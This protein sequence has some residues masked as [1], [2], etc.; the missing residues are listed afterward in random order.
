MNET[1]T[2]E[3]I[4]YSGLNEITAEMSA[5]LDA[6]RTA[7]GPSDHSRYNWA[8]EAHH[9]CLKNLV[10]L[11]VDWKKRQPIGLDGRWRV[12]EGIRIESE[13]KKWFIDIGYELTQSQR[14]FK[15]DDPGMEEFYDLWI[16]GKIDGMSPL[17]RKLPEPFSHLREAPAE[18]KTVNPNYWN[19]TKT[20]EDIKRHQ[21]FWIAKIPS[22]LNTYLAFTKSPGGFLIIV[23]FGKKPRI[24]PMLF[25]QELWDHDRA[26]ARK[27]NAHVEAGTYPEPMPFNATVC[28]MCDF[29]HICQPIR[30]T[31]M[32]GIDP[33]DIFKLEQYLEFKDQKKKFDELHAELIGTKA[34]P[35]KYHGQDGI[36]EDIEIST[37]SY[38]KKKYEIPGEVK[39]KYQVDDDEIITTKIER[40]SP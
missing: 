25:D 38:M 27:V 14:K 8:S 9:P 15:T 26:V 40:R 2:S 35:G 20:I 32:K 3:E 23:T 4:L 13:V 6:E 12:D 22:Q 39:E 36:I 5:K 37:S 31:K 18:V 34:K 16:S 7:W 11:R 17:N 33:L 30:P 10:H 29:N 19:S 28:G 21:A 1:A 24:L